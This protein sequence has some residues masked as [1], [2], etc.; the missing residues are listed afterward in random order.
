MVLKELYSLFNPELFQASALPLDHHFPFPSVQSVTAF[1]S[2]AILFYFQLMLTLE[3][4][5]TYA[6]LQVI[7]TRELDVAAPRQRIKYGF[8]PK[9]MRPPTEGREGDP[10]PLQHGDRITV[11]ILPDPNQSMWS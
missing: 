9:E 4:E 11:E 3:K 1:V 6:G 7:L 2:R 8:P 5:T 10:L